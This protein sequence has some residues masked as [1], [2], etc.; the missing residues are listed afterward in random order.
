M[1][2]VVSMFVA[3]WQ[4]GTTNVNDCVIPVVIREND[5]RRLRR[6]D[7]GASG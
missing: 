4:L 6:I 7:A 5:R 3:N 2:S 1:I